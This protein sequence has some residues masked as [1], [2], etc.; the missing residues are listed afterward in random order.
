MSRGSP[1]AQLNATSLDAERIRLVEVERSARDDDRQARLALGHDRELL[2]DLERQVAELVGQGAYPSTDAVVVEA[3]EAMLLQ[4]SSV[5]E[6]RL[7]ALL[8]EAEDTGGYTEMTAQDWEDIE[9][10]GLARA[11]ARKRA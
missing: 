2:P 6:Q 1:Y 9:R 7:E 5:D 3:L 11:H 8:Q 10:D 4:R